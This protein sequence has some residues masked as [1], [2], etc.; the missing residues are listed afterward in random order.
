MK[1]INIILNRPIGVLMLW[2][3][4]I[5]GGIWAAA[6]MTTDF[7]P[8][9][10]VP[11]LSVLTTCAGL[12]AEEMRRMVTIP[13]EDAL[14]SVSGLKNINSTSRDGVS[15]IMLEFPWGTDRTAAGIQTR[16]AVDLCWHS[17]PSKASKRRVLS[18]AP[19]DIAILTLAVLP[20]N[21]SLS[22]ARALADRDIRSR[23]QQVDGVG[24]IR[25]SGGTV[26]EVHIDVDPAAAAAAGCTI[27]DISA[28]VATCNI[29]CPA[30]S[31]TEGRTDYLIK[32]SHK[33]SGIE[34]IGRIYITGSSTAGSGTGVRLKD[35][36]VLSRGIKKQNSFYLLAA[37]GYSREDIRECIR[38]QIQSRG[39]FPPS[40]MAD[41]VKKELAEIKKSFKDDVSILI[42]EDRSLVLRDSIRSILLSLVSGAFFAFAVVWIFMKNLRRAMII[43]AILPASVSTTLLLLFLAGK[44]LN[45]MSIG[46]I[47]IGVGMVIDNAI[48]VLERLPANS[49]TRQAA[50]A[51]TELASPLAG[52]TATS[53]IVYLPL[54]ML[55]GLT[56][57]LF[58][59]L[60][61]S[62]IFALCSSLAASVTLIPVLIISVSDSTSCSNSCSNKKPGRLFPELRRLIRFSLRRPGAV[63]FIAASLLAAGLIPAHYL[64][65]EVISPLKEGRIHCTVKLPPG[66]SVEYV[67]DSAEEIM[68]RL[69]G[70]DGVTDAAAWAGGEYTDPVYLTSTEE[71][72]ET[73]NISVTHKTGIDTDKVTT[74]INRIIQIQGAES[75]IRPPES[76]LD[77]LIGIKSCHDWL[78][79]GDSPDSVRAAAEETADGI[80]GAVLLPGCK[81]PQI[82]ILP[83]LEAMAALG[84]DLP[85]L[86]DSLA[87]NI[88]GEIPA[89]LSSRTRDIDIRVRGS[90]QALSSKREVL[91]IC[92]P[93][94]QQTPVR[95]HSLVNQKESSTLPYLTRENRKDVT[96]IRLAAEADAED[97][98]ILKQNGARPAGDAVLRRQAAEIIE[99]LIISAILLYICLGVQFESFTVPLL[100]MLCIPPGLSGIISLT[101]LCG[102]A[103]NLNSVLGL[104]VVM[105]TSVNNGIL[106]YRQSMNLLRSPGSLPAGALYRGTASRLRPIMMTNLT[107]IAALLPLAAAPF[108]ESAQSSLAV[109]II[110][111][112]SVTCIISILVLPVIMLQPLKRSAERIRLRWE[113]YD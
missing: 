67:K 70:V 31:I 65:Y 13:L 32:T 86:A 71:S 34:D 96:V 97:E 74:G 8:E 22:A 79:Y 68:G 16:E 29:E 81:K 90:R 12:P 44:S 57:A 3:G 14:S 19:G 78:L 99:T 46:G 17:L 95:L 52:S 47:A 112:L 37:S 60:G 25:V 38:I 84:I 23:L 45:L 82:R 24:S 2:T 15:V 50:E 42:T 40:E 59:D 28:A 110:G 49:S 100:I 63:F 85:V 94:R 41:N 98:A 73:I 54:L 21:C 66:S 76:I 36:A 26:E 56:G 33:A 72:S 18:A 105:G 102:G 6:S 1:I 27:S 4:I 87:L 107:T 103:F 108:G 93:N 5:T 91:N 101:G 11:E 20:G 92:I 9:L 61:L 64:K 75:Y 55:G 104:M 39:G 62:V 80:E 69:L 10:C 51:L 30:G 88:K 89:V 106:F 113:A 109:S 111:G 77:K 48:V 7:L 58:A 53:V 43:T 35:T 83:D